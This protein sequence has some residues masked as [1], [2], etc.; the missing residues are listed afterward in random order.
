M[1]GLLS[2]VST[3]YTSK[4][5]DLILEVRKPETITPT[6]KSSLAH[7]SSPEEALEILKNEPSHET[8]LHTLTYLNKETSSFDIRTPDPLASQLIQVLVSEIVPTFWNVLSEASKDERRS[9]KKTKSGKSHVDVLID[10]L[11]SVPALSAINLNLKQL[12]QLLKSKQKQLGGKNSAEESLKSVLQLTEVLLRGE[13]LVQDIWRNIT[14]TSSTDLS[15]KAL[16]NELLTLLG[17][18]LVGI[19]AEAEVV[20]QTTSKEARIK[21]WLSDN[22]QYAKWIAQNISAWTNN[23]PASDAAGTKAVGELLSKS[24]RLGHTGKAVQSALQVA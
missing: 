15:R 22:V 21:T 13:S 7:A 12:I 20:H 6:A 23:L 24:F 11:R 4:S 8:L 14:R 17:G 19:V 16:W 18:K 3:S 2:P 10:C 1:D 5:D 9:K